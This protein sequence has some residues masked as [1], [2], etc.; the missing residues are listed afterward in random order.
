[1][2][3]IFEVPMDV[4]IKMA[5]EI[6]IET[7]LETVNEVS[8][9]FPL[10]SPW[11]LLL[12]FPWKLLFSLR[13]VVEIVVEVAMET[14]PEAVVDTTLG[15]CRIC[16]CVVI[17]RIIVL[18]LDVAFIIELVWM[19]EYVLETIMQCLEFCWVEHV[20][21]LPVVLFSP[22]NDGDGLVFLCQKARRC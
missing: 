3:T 12:K 17:A 21:H 1:M 18:S 19:L 22:I 16:V 4:A 20:V 5:M 15:N 14:D 11:K 9:E 13:S 6:A 7:V 10:N 2:Q 8:M